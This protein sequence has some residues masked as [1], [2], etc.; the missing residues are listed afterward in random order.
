VTHHMFTII[1]FV[2]AQSAILPL[3]ESEFNR[4]STKGCVGPINSPTA[5]SVYSLFEGLLFCLA[6][7]HSFGSWADDNR[8]RSSAC[9]SAPVSN[10]F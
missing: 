8:Y 3:C 5:A 1:F 10:Y 6:E 2:S 7:V 4:M 9:S